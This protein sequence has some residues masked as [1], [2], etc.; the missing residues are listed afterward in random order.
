MS[1]KTISELLEEFIRE[2]PECEYTQEKFNHDY[3]RIVARICEKH[4]ITEDQ[5]DELIRTHNYYHDAEDIEDQYMDIMRFAECAGWPR[6]PVVLTI[7][8]EEY[9]EN[10]D[11]VCCVSEDPGAHACADCPRR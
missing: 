11:R 8:V 1:D 9:D 5:I 10:G 4:G 2:N 7:S 6:P 3:P